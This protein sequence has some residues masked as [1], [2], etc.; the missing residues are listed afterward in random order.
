MVLMFSNSIRF[1]AQAVTQHQE[2]LSRSGE[3]KIA[4]RSH[5]ATIVKF[6]RPISKPNHTLQISTNILERLYCQVIGIKF[7]FIKIP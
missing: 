7:Q 3:N 2:A 4:L 6:D 5:C 1:A